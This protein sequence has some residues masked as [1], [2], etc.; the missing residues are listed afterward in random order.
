MR[1]LM[2]SQG[3]QGGCEWGPAMAEGLK[4]DS[5]AMD[6]GQPSVEAVV[7]GRSEIESASEEVASGRPHGRQK[8]GGG[9]HE[10]GLRRSAPSGAR[11]QSRC[12]CRAA[13][14]TWPICVCERDPP[15]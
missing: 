7:R 1:S 4:Q 15:G 2:Q 10:T 6:G 11:A 12:P 8:L 13:H 9:V 14:G 3:F 5:R